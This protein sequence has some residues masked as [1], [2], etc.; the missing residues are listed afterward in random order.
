MF[1]YWFGVLVWVLPLRQVTGLRSCR[2]LG[3]SEDCVGAVCGVRVWSVSPV[4]RK[5]GRRRRVVL[6]VCLLRV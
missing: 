1:V 3:R 4:S 2:T 6:G 5:G